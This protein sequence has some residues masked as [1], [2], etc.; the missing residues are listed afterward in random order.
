LLHN[1]AEHDGKR[2]LETRIP[3]HIAKQL[4]GAVIAAFRQADATGQNGF[5][6]HQNTTTGG[7]AVQQIQPMSIGDLA[8][9]AEIA[10]LF[11][12][13]EQLGRSAGNRQPT[14]RVN[15]P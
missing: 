9:M 3:S 2:L 12:R 1:P 13:P 15:V 11:D 8:K 14:Q 6:I 10:D 5:S 4:K 7:V